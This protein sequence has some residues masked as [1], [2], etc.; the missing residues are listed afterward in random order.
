MR[1]L[2]AGTSGLLRREA[3]GVALPPSY[4][5]GWLQSAPRRFALLRAVER[6]TRR[7]TASL[8]DHY[9]LEAVRRWMP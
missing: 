5:A 9:M 1:I 4:A 6:V 7:F 8:A 2:G 3:V